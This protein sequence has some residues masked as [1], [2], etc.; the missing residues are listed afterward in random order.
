VKVDIAV[1]MRGV[2][3][4]LKSQQLL[5]GAIGIAPAMG[6][7]Y[8]IGGFLKDKVRVA[9]GRQGKEAGMGTRF[10]AWEAMRRIDRLLANPELTSGPLPPLT[11][12]LLL[13]DLSLLRSLSPLLL[14]QASKGRKG[15]AKRLRSEFLR[16]VRDL[17]SSG[18]SKQGIQSGASTP[19][20]L[21]Q[22]G[23]GWHARR[24][25]V[26]R[27]WRSWGSVMNLVEV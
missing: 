16:D 24:A 14:S 8:Y 2:D 18:I 11:Q 19:L 7:T 5:F 1:A 12:G 22:V 13:L 4:L 25:A 9:L 27:M 17:E 23:L 21:S 10:R 26:D 6:I 15:T 3:Q 20:T